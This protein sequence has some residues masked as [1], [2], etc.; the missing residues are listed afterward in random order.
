MLHRSTGQTQH[1]PRTE[2]P[3]ND[4]PYSLPK[5]AE[6]L[7]KG[8]VNNVSK[9]PLW[10]AFWLRFIPCCLAGQT[11]SVMG[12][13]WLRGQLRSDLFRGVANLWP[14]SALLLPL[15]IA[16]VP[17]MLAAFVG[18]RAVWT[19]TPAKRVPAMTWAAKTTSLVYFGWTAFIV[20]Q[21][22]MRVFRQVL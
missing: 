2:Y 9:L 1:T 15:V 11:I 16:A 21:V 22:F 10:K 18:T 6:S 19:A 8:D 13:W 12:L 14:I 20:A 3:L 5:T 4:T 7:E 17:L